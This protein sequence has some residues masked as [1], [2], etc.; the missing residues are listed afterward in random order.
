MNL[1]YGALR[2]AISMALQRRAKN[3]EYS[4]DKPFEAKNCFLVHLC[5][6]DDERP[7]LITGV[8]PEG[9]KGLWFNNDRN[10]GERGLDMCIPNSKIPYFTLSIM[11]F[12][13]ETSKVY[14]S[15]F[16]F[17]V[18]QWLFVPYVL[19]YV[20]RARQFLF[21]RRKLARDDRIDVLRHIYLKTLHD[22]EYKTGSIGL[23]SEVYGYRWLYHP[24]KR[25]IQNH[26]ELVL[27]SLEKSGDLEISDYMFRLAPGALTTLAAYEEE[28]R[29]HKDNVR[30]QAFLLFLTLALVLV[31]TLNLICR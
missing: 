16:K 21:N 23:A 5:P 9:L 4:S 6:K 24:E 8:Y 14:K 2:Y 10:P 17:I 22:R 20:G 18:F 11:H 13:D 29:R 15:A 19:L 7:P 1:K 12:L 28:E 3:P 27:N 30:L 31:E 26:Y 25:S